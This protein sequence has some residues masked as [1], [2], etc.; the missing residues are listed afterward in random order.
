MVVFEEKG[1]KEQNKNNNYND[2][3][4]SSEGL[5]REAREVDE[6]EAWI[7]RREAQAPNIRRCSLGGEERAGREG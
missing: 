3:V 1:V 5:K 7:V 4:A 6:R 2:S